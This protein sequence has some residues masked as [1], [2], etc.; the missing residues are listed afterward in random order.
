MKLIEK[1]HGLTEAEDAA[2]KL[3]EHGILTHISSK[4]SYVMSGYVTGAFTVGLWA[5]LDEQFEDAKALLENPKHTVTTGKTDDEIAEI[6]NAS[7]QS[8]HQF[9]N[10][11][12]FYGALFFVLT[13]LA[14]YYLI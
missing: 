8:V 13:A 9:F 11:F 10:G 3:R 6:E 7:N 5:V 1:Y 14:I 2:L 4:N 12:L